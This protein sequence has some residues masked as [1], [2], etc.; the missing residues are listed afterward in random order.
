LQT[1]I[2]AMEAAELF[3]WDGLEAPAVRAKFA[4]LKAAAA[5][6]PTP[7]ERVEDVEMDVSGAAPLAARLY[8]PSP[9][10]SVPLL[11]WFHGGGWVLGGVDYD[12][13]A[14]RR[15]A[16]AG[17]FAVLSVA[18]RLAPEHPYPAA[19][20]D[21]CAA[22]AWAHANAPSLECGVVAIGGA[23]AGGNLAAVATLDAVRR[24]VTPPAHQFLVYPAVDAT[25]SADSIRRYADGPVLTA[26]HMDWFYERYL[27]AEVNRDDWRV[28]PINAPSLEGLP[29]ASV[30]VAS[31]DPLVDEGRAYAGLLASAG[32]DAELIEAAGLVHGFFGMASVVS[33]A[34][35]VLSQSAIRLGRAL[36]AIE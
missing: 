36:A 31:H 7:I 1:V 28:S 5:S 32:C 16:V 18:Y 13:E 24:G 35:A 23:S 15:M 29:P 2:D 20:N 21:A 19:F 10:T 11:V 34:N 26:A 25:C 8:H 3:N 4:A 9:G 27:P 33:A 6:A 12:D 30:V 14:C 17:D 22:L